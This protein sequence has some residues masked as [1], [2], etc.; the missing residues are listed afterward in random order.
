[1]TPSAAAR[2][3]TLLS[4]IALAIAAACPAHAENLLDRTG[5]AI[6]GIARSTGQALGTMAE[7]T[8]RAVGEVACGIGEGA[9]HIADPNAP[10]TCGDQTVVLPDSRNPNVNPNASTDQVK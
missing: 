3:L 2:S 8:G 10:D 1:M 5:D 6:G 4:A 7:G 9:Q